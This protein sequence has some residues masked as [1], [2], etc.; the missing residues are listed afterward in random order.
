MNAKRNL[1]FDDYEMEPRPGCGKTLRQPTSCGE[2]E[3]R[4]AWWLMAAALGGVLFLANYLFEFDVKWRTPGNMSERP[5]AQTGTG[6]SVLPGARS[7]SPVASQP[8][9]VSGHG[10]TGQTTILP[11]NYRVKSPAASRTRNP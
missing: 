3:T 11:G 9:K 2:K 5:L 4:A 1:S 6:S 10:I 7:G 8:A